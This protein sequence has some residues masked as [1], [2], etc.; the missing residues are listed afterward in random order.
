ME[1]DII[2]RYFTCQTTEEE[3]KA[4]LN[5]IKASKEN[6]VLFF[7]L[8]TIWHTYSEQK[9]EDPWFLKH[10]LNNLNQ[11][12]DN[13]EKQANK[14]LFSRKYLYLWSSAAAIIAI[15][16]IF[17]VFYTMKRPVSLAMHTIT[18]VFSDSVMQIKLTDGSTVW[19][20]SGASLSYPD[21]FTADTRSV[22]LKGN[23]FFEIAKDSLHPFIVSTELYRIKVLGTIF[24]INTSNTEDMGEAVLLEGSIQL[25]KANGENLVVLQ[26]GQQVLFTNDYSSVKVNKID[27]RQHTLWRFGLVCLSDVSLDEI[28]SSLEE[29]YHVKI[30]M[31]IHQLSDRRYNFSFKQTNSLEDALRHLFYLTGVQATVLSE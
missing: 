21:E 17:S 10:S 11:R 2:Y 13:V 20:N 26:P 15:F 19:L 14:H 25:E 22:N 4:V 29:I 23:A 9:K 16:L 18:N 8:K 12:I 7:E 1:E 3:D 24:S 31:D 30:Q 28:L 6:E 5:W 27:A